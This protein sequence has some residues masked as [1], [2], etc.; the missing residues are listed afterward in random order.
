[1]AQTKEPSETAVNVRTI[2]QA[3]ELTVSTQV[4]K[5]GQPPVDKEIR[6]EILI[7]NGEPV[8]KLQEEGKATQTV[9]TEGPIKKLRKHVVQS[10]LQKFVGGCVFIVY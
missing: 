7:I 3:G 8:L 9:T 6:V 1:M 4:R 2:P 10:I 5:K